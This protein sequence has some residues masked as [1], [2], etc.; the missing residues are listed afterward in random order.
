MSDIRTTKPGDKYASIRNPRMYRAL[1]RRGF[2]KTSAA[3]ITNARS[4][5][6]DDLEQAVE[7]GQP[8]Y[9][10]DA[11]A[12]QCAELPRLK[13]EQIAPGITR[14]RGNL[15]NVHG[16]YGKCPG[17][18]VAAPKPPPAKTGRRGRK[19][20]KPKKT[21]QERAAELEA[22][23]QAQD[24][25][26]RA[27][28]DKLL[29][30]AGIDKNTQG[31]LVDA[32]E[33][34]TLTSANGAKLA[35][36]G[37]AEQAADGSYRL[38]ASGRG[39]VDAALRGDAGRVQDTMS[40]ARDAA[41]KRAAAKPA[42]GG[43]GGGKAKP[44]KPTE[45]EKRTQRDQERSQRASETAARVGL[46]SAHVSDL[47]TAAEAGGVQNPALVQLGFVD[48]DGLAT[49]QGRRALSALE[50]GDVRGYNAAAQDARGRMARENAARV[51]ASEA[52]RRRTIA[53]QKR[54]AAEQARQ[55]RDAERAARAEA[56]RTE[57]D[58]KRAA[59]RAR[60]EAARQ[61]TRM[62]KAARPYIAHWDG[63]RWVSDRP[64]FAVFK[65]STGRDR[66]LSVTTTA[67][68]DRD[69]EWISRKAIEGAVQAGDATGVRGPLR[70]WHVPGLDLGTC[71]YQATAQD[72]RFLIESGTFK[73]A[74]AA[75]IGRAA[76][77]KG[78]QMSPGFV[79]PADEP[80]GGVFDHITI[81]ERSIVPAGRASNP[82]TRL[83]V[84]GERMLTDEKKKEFET[85]AGDAESR[86]FLTQLLSTVQ[87]T[88]KAAQ[89]S[90]TYKATDDSTRNITINLSYPASASAEGLAATVKAAVEQA[91]LAEKAAPPFSPAD[92]E[93]AVEAEAKMDGE[94]MLMEEEPSAEG[95]LT[96]SPEDLTAIGEAFAAQLAPA[97]AQVM[98]ALDLE[99]KVAGHVQTMLQPYQT[100]K[101][102]ADAE[103]AAE[104][105]TLQS[106]LK[107]TNDKLAELM[108]ETPAAY[109]GHRITDNPVVSEAR[110][111]QL[112][113]TAPTAADF[114]PI[115]AQLMGNGVHIPGN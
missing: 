16:R 99:K 30:D 75:R 70:F 115:V 103:R 21:E 84:K 42:K 98:G 87:T 64:T 77:D 110:K 107:A 101:D 34:N 94:E 41:A 31:A 68:Q 48:A 85:L 9:L 88:D 69:R 78:Y 67:Y 36:M 76:A 38:T 39:V 61:E 93:P 4:K 102:A 106:T 58:R 1:R 35:S 55:A 81:F 53:D 43:G 18:P 3:K 20:A 19:P 25:E 24:A 65:D 114:D 73:H 111:E 8:Q 5:S 26:R 92:E 6:V 23:R 37:L 96:L 112:V 66:W 62:Q 10:I 90:A 97:L 45:D 15:C 86:A 82:F 100:Q 57:P 56:K 105:A 13:G 50:R 72:G 60:R 28:R 11:I 113:P 49:D 27:T 95:G 33:G 2:D 52:E 22:K 32:R 51:R 108:G 80:R 7:A 46:G 29:A 47:R 54:Q 12:A 44:A 83:M 63:T 74:V 17:A 14:I 40:A 104:I 109:K 71:D 59:R 79:H 89:E 91:L